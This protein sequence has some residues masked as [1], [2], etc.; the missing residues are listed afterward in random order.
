MCNT[1]GYFDD[2]TS[3]TCPSCHYSC[4]SCWGPSASQCYSCSSTSFRTID[5]NTCYCDPRYYDDSSNEVCRTCHYTCYACSNN[6][7]TNCLTCAASDFREPIASNNSCG[8]MTG[9]YD[10]GGTNN[11]CGLCH[12]TCLTCSGGNEANKCVTCDLNN[13][14]RNL[15]SGA[16]PCIDGYYNNLNPVCALCHVTCKTCNGGTANDCTDCDNTKFRGLTSGQCK[17]NAKYYEF[18]LT[19]QPC[20]YTCFNCTGPTMYECTNCNNAVTFRN[21]NGTDSSCYC[22]A[23]Y[24]EPPVQN[25]QCTKCDR[26]CLT[27]SGTAMTCI[28]C[29]PLK[30]R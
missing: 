13:E 6:G 28:T 9:Y 27:C 2:N 24:T 8:C 1:I 17:C 16:C 29:D 23:G 12:Y 19:C 5:I 3:Q 7:A 22:I 14:L 20:H 4:E 15:S 26:T 25:A 10:L 11:V 21:F 30:F 18:N